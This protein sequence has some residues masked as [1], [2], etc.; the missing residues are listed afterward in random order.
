VTAQTNSE[1]QNRMD[2]GTD[3]TLERR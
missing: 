1:R 3:L 2:G